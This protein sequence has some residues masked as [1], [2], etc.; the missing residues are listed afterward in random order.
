[1][2][3]KIAYLRGLMDGLKLADDDN[4][5]VLKAIADCLEAIADEVEEESARVD[6]IEAELD[7]I[8]SDLDDMDETLGLL[9]EEDEDDEDDCPFDEDE[10]WEDDFDFFTCPNCGEVVPL[11]DDMLEKEESPICPKCNE[12]LFDE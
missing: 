6:N 7:E 3:Q 12:K 1:M 2:K 11:T 9:L 10:D 8:D 5:K 4:T